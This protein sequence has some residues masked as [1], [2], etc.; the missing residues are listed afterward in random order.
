MDDDADEDDEARLDDAD[1]GIEPTDVDPNAEAD[2]DAPPEPLASEPSRDTAAV[3]LFN[4]RFSFS[5]L[6]VCSFTYRS[7][8][9]LANEVLSKPT[10]EDDD[11]DEEDGRWD[12]DEEA[13][14]DEAF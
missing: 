9:D 11:A 6:S 2:A 8:Y 13:D 7:T 1:V 5:G 10:P 12:E 4:M 14:D 3:A